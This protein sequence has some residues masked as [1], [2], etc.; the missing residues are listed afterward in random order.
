MDVNDGCMVAILYPNIQLA[1]RI[2]G[3]FCILGVSAN[4]AELCR[5][6]IAEK[7]PPVQV[8]EMNVKDTLH[9]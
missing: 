4:I 2:H 8:S 7:T 1:N 5:T 6:W 3:I 9:V